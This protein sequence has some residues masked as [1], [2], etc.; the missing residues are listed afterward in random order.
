MAVDAQNSVRIPEVDWE[1]VECCPLCGGIHDA[2]SGRLPGERYSF[3][4]QLAVPFPEGGICLRSCSTCGLYFKS[5]VPSVESMTSLA[6]ILQGDIWSEN[7]SHRLE[8]EFSLSCTT[9][10]APRIFEVGPGGGEFISTVKTLASSVGAIDTCDLSALPNFEDAVLLKGAIDGELE[11]TDMRSAYDIVCAFDV[12]EHLRY[13]LVA[14]ENISIILADTG[15][16]VV[17][18]GDIDSQYAKRFGRENW[19]YVNLIEHNIFWS[20]DS[21]ENVAGAGFRVNRFER[22]VHK[23]KR[24][25]SVGRRYYSDLQ[26]LLYSASPHLFSYLQQSLGR[27][28]RQPQSPRDADHLLIQ[29]MRDA[30]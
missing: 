2:W 8:V 18:T 21:L 24:A 5:R 29:F 10:T 6:E 30:H 20:R 4:G 22:H 19:W 23:N 13:P 11:L 15:S 12:F 16:L 26:I 1:Q 9:R 3:A 17:S 28:I 25:A 27:E 7:V 14:M